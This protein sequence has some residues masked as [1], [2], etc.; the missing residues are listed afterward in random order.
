MLKKKT[1]INLEVT[2]RKLSK[3]ML[4]KMAFKPF[5]ENIQNMK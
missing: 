3:D 1:K 2:L 5:I 4:F